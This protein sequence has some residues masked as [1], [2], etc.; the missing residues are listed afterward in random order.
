[1]T[2]GMKVVL[3]A[4]TREPV[5]T[6][7]ATVV[8]MLMG[9]TESPDGKGV[10]DDKEVTEGVNEDDTRAVGERF[11]LVVD[12][13]VAS[14]RRPAHRKEMARRRDKNIFVATWRPED[15]LTWLAIDKRAGSG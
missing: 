15:R 4:I 3:F 2:V 11:T 12:C 14:S 7:T 13:A 6:G 1:M 8:V 10:V 9:D 5:E